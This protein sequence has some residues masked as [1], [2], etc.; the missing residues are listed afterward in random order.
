MIVHL[1]VSAHQLDLRTTPAGAHHLWFPST[2]KDFERAEKHM[3]DENL[4]DVLDD[5]ADYLAYKKKKT[6][7]KL[8]ERTHLTM[9]KI[10]KLV[11]HEEH[12]SVVG[13]ITLQELIDAALPDAVAAALE[14]MGDDAPAP[15]ADPPA[16]R[17]AAK[18]AAKKKTAVAA[19]KPVAKKAAKKKAAKKTPSAKAATGKKADYG[20]KKPRLQREQGYKEILAALKAAGEPC[21]RGD[22]EEATGYTGVQVRTF[23]K[24]LAALTPPKVTVLGKGGRSTKYE[25]ASKS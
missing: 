5:K 13:D 2:A 8:G 14:E 3:S 24:E 7:E 19:K 18:K 23:C 21:G 9:A 17:P 15:S 1:Q 11:A 22:L 16:S 25:L 20:K 6:I 4:S 10:A 12:G